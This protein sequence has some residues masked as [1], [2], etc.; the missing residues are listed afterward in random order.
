MIYVQDPENE[1]VMDEIYA[2]MSE[3]EKGNNGIVAMPTENGT[4]PLVFGHKRMIEHMK[5]LVQ[6]I[7]NHTNKKV[8]LY[9]FSN[10]EVVEE[11]K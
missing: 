10:R 2:F 9:K 5:P 6:A 7:A 8:V 3:D 4:V 1:V 11:I